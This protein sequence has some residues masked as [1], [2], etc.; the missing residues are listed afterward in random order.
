MSKST[1]NNK[2]GLCFFRGNSFP[3]RV[4]L[5]LQWYL[6]STRRKIFEELFFFA[7]NAKFSQN[8]LPFALKTLVSTPSLGTLLPPRGGLFS[9]R[10][11]SLS[12]RW[13][14]TLSGVPPF[15]Q[16]CLGSFRALQTNQEKK[17]K[18]N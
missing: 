12:P 13:V 14:S 4:S 10:G 6:T 5:L 8:D 1:T 11:T 15:H 16:E 18:F 9:F 2:G 17:V 7:K 3:P